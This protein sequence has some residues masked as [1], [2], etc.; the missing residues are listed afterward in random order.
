MKIT[1]IAS[2]VFVAAIVSGC[3]KQPEAIQAS[4]VSPTVFADRNCASIVTERNRVVQEVNTVSAA[5]KKKANSDAVATGVGT[6]LFWPAL[7]MLATGGDN[8][9]QLATL[10]G[11]YDALTEA[12]TA[13]GCF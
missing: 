12:G 2:I 3:A 4:Y 11:N 6:I 10:K 13:K 8:E 1:S 7:F 5:Q 9:A